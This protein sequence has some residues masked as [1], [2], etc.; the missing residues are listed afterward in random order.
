MNLQD[1]TLLITGGTSGIGYALVKQLSSTSKSIVVIARN[2]VHL[3][4]LK[5]EFPNVHI[6]KCALANKIDLEK[7]FSEIINNHPDIS[8]VINNAGIQATPTFLDKDFNFDSIEN[9]ISVNL[10]APIR[11]CALMLG[12]LLN[13]KAPAAIVNITS[14]LGLYPKKNSAV[15][16]ATKAGL[17]NFT[18]SFRYQ[19]EETPIKVFEAIM[20]LVDTPMTH[21]RGKG[22]ISPDSAAEAI[23]KGIENDD[24]EIFVGKAKLIPLV[25]RISP[26]LMAAIMKAG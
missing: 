26:T 19:L 8:V 23:I 10:M 21:G 17:R 7:T 20:P 13:L 15:Y 24:E 11:I 16:C 6:Y 14:G 25:A 18:Q 1:K 22:K 5:N 9:E 12:P 4:K 3:E 2:S